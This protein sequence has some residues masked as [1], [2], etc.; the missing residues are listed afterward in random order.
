MKTI[1]GVFSIYIYFLFEVLS[2]KKAI[3][4]LK[5]VS[6]TFSPPN[7]MVPVSRDDEGILEVI[8]FPE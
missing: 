6:G 7:L 1:F 4:N 3:T 5:I 8:L 2:M